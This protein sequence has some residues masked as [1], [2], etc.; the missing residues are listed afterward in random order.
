MNQLGSNASC[1]YYEKQ[2]EA[3]PSERYGIQPNGIWV[4]RV[5]IGIFNVCLGKWP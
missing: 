2:E 4:T 1:Q 5:C 3:T